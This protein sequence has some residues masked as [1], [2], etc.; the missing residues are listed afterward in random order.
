MTITVHDR[1]EHSVH[2][3][4]PIPHITAPTLSVREAAEVLG[5]S[6]QHLHNLLDSGEIPVR[7]L[8]LGRRLSV[9]TESLRAFLRG[10]PEGAAD[11][12]D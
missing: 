4:D 11:A 10:T 9:V 7:A 5:I 12:A 1:N 8:R 2:E 3:N 6:R